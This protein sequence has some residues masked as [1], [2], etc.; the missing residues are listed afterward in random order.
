MYSHYLKNLVYNYI[1]NKIIKYVS[2]F[3]NHDDKFSNKLKF[4]GLSL[5][6]NLTSI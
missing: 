6:K 5:I 3:Y 1:R 2:Q 4:V